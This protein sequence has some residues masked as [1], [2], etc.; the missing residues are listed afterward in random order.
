[1]NVAM[2]LNSSYKC[3]RNICCTAPYTDYTISLLLWMQPLMFGSTVLPEANF[4]TSFIIY[5]PLRCPVESACIHLH[6]MK[7][8]AACHCEATS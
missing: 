3:Y 8:C 5:W 7:H 2:R 4:V 6:N 1:M